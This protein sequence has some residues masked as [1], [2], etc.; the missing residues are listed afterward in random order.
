MV[1][2]CTWQL[3]GCLA[4]Q[5]NEQKKVDYHHQHTW[6]HNDWHASPIHACADAQHRN[7]RLFARDVQVTQMAM[8][9]CGMTRSLPT[10]SGNT[11][12]PPPPTSCHGLVEK[13]KWEREARG[14]G[15]EGGGAVVAT[16]HMGPAAETE[17]G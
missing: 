3:T 9:P 6:R 11:N 12:A 14:L 4:L 16:V 8:V 17:T 10:I 7:M 15:R 2:N 13:G 5:L 1:Q